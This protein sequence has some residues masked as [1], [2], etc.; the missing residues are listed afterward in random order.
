MISKFIVYIIQEL[1]SG[2]Y[3]SFAYWLFGSEAFMALILGAIGTFSRR[4]GQQA[5]GSLET[6]VMCY[7][8]AMFTIVAAIT[9]HRERW[10]ID[11]KPPLVLRLIAIVTFI[12]LSTYGLK[13]AYIAATVEETSWIGLGFGALLIFFGVAQ[14]RSVCTVGWCSQP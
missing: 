4:Y 1:L 13:I 2:K 9:Y 5:D 11:W 14:I 12:G 7:W 3:P 8:Y 10:Q 6:V